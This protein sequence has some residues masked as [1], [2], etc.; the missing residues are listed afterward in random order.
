VS[1]ELAGRLTITWPKAGQSH[2]FG[3][4]IVLHD[5]D[6]GEQILS[7]LSFDLVVHADAKE[8]I[9]ADVTMLATADGLPLPADA[10]PV[11]VGEGDSAEVAT[12]RFR[13][14]VAEMRIAE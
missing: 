11:I 8:L 10:K 5:A 7:A 3:G 4:R 2:L 6:S 12:G 14:A 13:W 1:G 9:T